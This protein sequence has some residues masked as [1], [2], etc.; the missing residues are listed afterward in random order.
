MLLGSVRSIFM[1][2]KFM[3]MWVLLRVF[4]VALEFP[5]DLRRLMVV[6]HRIYMCKLFLMVFPVVLAIRGGLPVLTVGTVAPPMVAVVFAVP[7][8]LIVMLRMPVM[9]LVMP[10]LVVPLLVMP[11]FVVPCMR[12]VSYRVV[13]RMVCVCVV[14]ALLLT[15]VRI[16]ML[17]CLRS[18]TINF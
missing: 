10:F 8:M 16:R 12:L 3:A 1:M 5:H 6:N 9:L 17:L 2:L 4:L 7:I 13:C 11:L 14:L 15:V 18:L